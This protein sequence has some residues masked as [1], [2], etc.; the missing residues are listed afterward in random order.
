[1][2]LK[3]LGEERGGRERR[4]NLPLHSSAMTSPSIAMGIALRL[5]QAHI[6]G[7][8]LLVLFARCH[9]PRDSS[10]SLSPASVQRACLFPDLAAHSSPFRATGVIKGTFDFTGF[11]LIFRAA[12]TSLLCIQMISPNQ[13]PGQRQALLPEPDVSFSP[14]KSRLETSRLINLHC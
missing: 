14:W 5:R 12:F 6:R 2:I 13:W 10:R 3:G 9:Q 8:N 1:M 11:F 7:N 4:E